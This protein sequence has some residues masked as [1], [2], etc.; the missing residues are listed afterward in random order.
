MSFWTLDSLRASMGARWLRRPDGA[1][2]REASGVSI[3]SRTIRPDEL[4]FAIEGERFDGHDYVGDAIDAGAAGVVVSRADAV[5]VVSGVAA[6]LVP[7]TGEAL[8]R[9][10]GAWRRSLDSL[11]VIGV[12]GSNGKTTAC[13]LIQSIL[14]QTLRGVAPERSFNNEIGVPL[15][16]LRARPGDQY[17]ICEVGANARGEIARLSRILEPDIAVVTSIGRAHLEGFG[18]VEAIVREKAAL[19]HH[20]RP[21][22][23]GVATAEAPLLAPHLRPVPN[24]ITFGVSEGATL[25][26]VSVDHIEEQG[27]TLLRFMLAD[28]SEFRTPLVGEHNAFNAAAA[29]A[30]A[31]RFGLSNDAIAEGLRRAT[32][33]EM[34]LAVRRLDA[35]T[36]VNDA[37]NANPDSTLAAVRAF[38]SLTPTAK[39]RVVVL[40][41]M[42]ELG[43]EAEA[44]HEQVGADIA[45]M[46]GVHRLIGVGSLALRAA[47]AASEIL[48]EENVVV[49]QSLSERETERLVEA[50]RWGDAALLKGS[51]AAR[52]ERL[53]EALLRRAGASAGAAPERASS[54]RAAG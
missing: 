27:R 13:R 7:E 21:G 40:G 1:D 34:R 30:V 33:A 43:D 46:N 44:L 31:R 42:L 11:R 22:G 41:D 25:R 24:A 47:A 54:S 2:E 29:V 23:L 17:L 18:S 9:L 32:P 3:D 4:F 39:R 51:R 53:E 45:Q 50:V 10:A 20:L 5:E 36:L 35:L 26:I 38:V 8:M 37:Y 15:T 48:G 19:L 14:S 49:A 16:I 52:L 12:T 28:R 6:L